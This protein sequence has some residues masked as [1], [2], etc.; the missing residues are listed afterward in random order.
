MSKTVLVTGCSHGG[1]GAAMAKVYR[2]KGFKVFATLRN[3]A[4]VGSLADMDGI[5]IVELEITS[6]ESIRRCADVVAKQTGGALDIL[7]NNAGVSC[8]VP[9]LDASLDDAKKVYDANVWSILAMAQAFA[10]ML[11]KSKGTMCNIS[12]VSGEMVF[13]WAGV[14]SSSRSAQTRLSETLR[15]EMAP[16]GVRVVTV[17]L[18]GVETSGNNPDNIADLELPPNS[19]YRKITTVIDR[20][21]KT[22]VHPNKQNVDTAAKNVVEDVLYGKGPF[23]RRGQASTLSWLCNTFLPYG[24]FTSMINKES[25]LDEIDFREDKA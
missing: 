3:K 7:V 4:K 9:L 16:L 1:L 17:I 12:S 25:A 8:I 21:K 24:L 23:I 11:I 5:E 6:V 20:H 14:Y 19:H 10:P 15:L 2:A 18:G 13:A 22:Q